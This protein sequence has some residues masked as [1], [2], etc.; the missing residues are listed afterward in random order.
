LYGIRDGD[1]E[2]CGLREKEEGRW[3]ETH[4]DVHIRTKKTHVEEV[5]E[6]GTKLE[7]IKHG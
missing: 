3:R 7:R 1:R 6:L 2:E 5:R 4:I